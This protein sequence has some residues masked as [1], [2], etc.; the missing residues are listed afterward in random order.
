MLPPHEHGC[1]SCSL[2]FHCMH[3]EHFKVLTN[4]LKHH[5]VR[6]VTVFVMISDRMTGQFI[7]LVLLEGHLK[8]LCCSPFTELW[9]H[10]FRNYKSTQIF[11]FL[12]TNAGYQTSGSIITLNYHGIIPLRADAIRITITPICIPFC[13]DC[14]FCASTLPPLPSPLSRTQDGV[15]A[16]PSIIS[17][18]A[19][20]VE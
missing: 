6:Q 10:W 17:A 7:P 12:G 8:S 19:S 5:Q 4:P 13:S 2:I 15:A 1:K 14:L 9:L 3:S 20:A 16:L 11:G 18:A